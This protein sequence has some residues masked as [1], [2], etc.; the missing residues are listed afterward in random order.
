M[1]RMKFLRRLLPQWHRREKD[2][3][4]W[5][6]RLVQDF[7]YQDAQKYATYVE[8]LTCP[9]MVR[10][11]RQIRYPKMEE[12]KELAAFLLHPKRQIHAA[13]SDVSRL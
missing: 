6:I 9:E 2:F 3:R 7:N 1:R 4:E 5:Y 12:A 10:G 8:V 13:A 11:Y